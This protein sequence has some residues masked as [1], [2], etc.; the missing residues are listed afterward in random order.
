MVTYIFLALGVLALV[1]FLA[2]RDKHGSALATCLKSLT[3][4]FFMATAI[5]AFC[6]NGTTSFDRIIIPAG[7]I[8]L[9]LIF[10]LVGDIL[11]DLKITYKRDLKDSDLYT[12]AGMLAFGVGHV[13]YIAAVSLLFDFNWWALLVAVGLAAVIFCTAILVL[14]MNFGKFL[15]PSISYGFLLSWFVCLVA[16]NCIT[17]GATTA[18]VLLLIGSIMFLVSDLILSMTYFDKKDGRVFIIANH[19]VYYAAQFLIAISLMFI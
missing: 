16:A 18:L 12:Y 3:S 8:L 15:I 9:G 19:V 2:F 11:L 1:A 10:G 13:L 14:K 7:L 6:E 17:A 4:L 5:A